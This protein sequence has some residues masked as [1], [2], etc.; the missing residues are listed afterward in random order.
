MKQNA[1]IF[2]ILTVV[3]C[4][5]FSCSFKSN[6]DQKEEISNSSFYDDKEDE[7]NEHI[8]GCKFEDGTYSAI[9]DYH[10]PET[11]FSATYTLDVDVQD[12]QVIQI[13]FPNSGYLD[14]DHISISDIDEYGNAMVD[15]EG[16]KTYE[17]HINE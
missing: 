13:N 11:G 15:G 8:S 7:S 14:E 12:C 17:I 2:F 9:V 5:F 3:V 4:I 6:N 16:G 10:N 1:I